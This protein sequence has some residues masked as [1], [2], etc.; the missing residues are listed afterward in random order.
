[1]SEAMQT[2]FLDIITEGIPLNFI[3]PTDSKVFYSRFYMILINKI[4]TSKYGGL[5]G[6][7]FSTNISVVIAL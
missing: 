3:H 6:E 5:N 2:N 1:M 7:K 4:F